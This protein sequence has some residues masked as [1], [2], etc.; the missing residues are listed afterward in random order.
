LGG[1]GDEVK[2]PLAQA[3]LRE[4]MARDA[5]FA[6]AFQAFIE[7]MAEEPEVPETMTDDRAADL[8]RIVRAA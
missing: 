5:E 6:L 2:F 3:V 7:G 4:E 1:G 8:A